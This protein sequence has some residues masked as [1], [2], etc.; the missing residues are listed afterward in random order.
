MRLKNKDRWINRPVSVLFPFMSKRSKKAVQSL[1]VRTIRELMGV[2]PVDMKR[3][4]NC[5]KKSINEIN[6]MLRHRF[7]HGL[8]PIDAIFDE[9]AK[10]KMNEDLNEERRLSFIEEKMKQAQSWCDFVGQD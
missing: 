8:N 7:G 10:A 3:L 4:K 6:E 5:S 2:R 1:N 9:I